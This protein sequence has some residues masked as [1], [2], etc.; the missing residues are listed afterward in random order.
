MHIKQG[1][2]VIALTLSSSIF[3]S[4]P[5]H[6]A[7]PEQ[8]SHGFSADEIQQKVFECLFYQKQKNSN[9]FKLISSD[10]GSVYA[11]K[12]DAL[13]DSYWPGRIYSTCMNVTQEMID[14]VEE[15]SESQN[16]LWFVLNQQENAEKNT[17]HTLE[18]NNYRKDFFPWLYL[19]VVNLQD[20]STKTFLGASTIQKNNSVTRLCDGNNHTWWLLLAEAN[21]VSTV[22]I[23]QLKRSIKFNGNGSEIFFFLGHRN[24]QPVSTCMSIISDYSVTIH[25][26]SSN[27]QCDYK[28]VAR[29]TIVAALVHAAELGCKTAWFLSD[30]HYLPDIAYPVATI[31]TY[32]KI[33]PRI[34]QALCINKIDSPN[35]KDKSNS[36]SDNDLSKCLIS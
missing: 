34:I 29:N 17:I 30:I 27:N 32:Q 8:K 12:I 1:F 19:Y 13:R 24:E 25:F 3:S 15:Y 23:G 18:K 7:S 11:Q 5:M 6:G 31:S 4:F 28:V 9:N 33:D 14:K 26:I 20:T 16:Y 36:Q 10:T 2:A 22:N 21:N 35:T